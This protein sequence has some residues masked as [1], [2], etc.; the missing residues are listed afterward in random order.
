MPFSIWLI[1]WLFRATWSTDKIQD[2]AS[3]IIKGR[4]SDP[5]GIRI[6]LGLRIQ[7]WRSMSFSIW[8]SGSPP[9]YSAPPK[10]QMSLKIMRKNC[11]HPF[12]QSF[13]SGW[14]PASFGSGDPDSALNVNLLFSATWST[15]KIQDHASRI[16]IGRASDTDGIQ[17]HL[18]Q[19]IQI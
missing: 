13:R 17:I 12:S 1:A 14:N 5:D 15:D 4:A 3:H 10:V 11:L 19:C 16:I 18:G 7:I 8:A 6:P 2:H 9:A